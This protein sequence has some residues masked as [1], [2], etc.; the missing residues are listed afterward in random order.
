V[1]EERMLND[2][3]HKVVK[4]KRGD[5]AEQTNH[6][7]NLEDHEADRFHQDWGTANRDLKFLENVGRVQQSIGNGQHQQERLRGIGYEPR[8]E[9]RRQEP[10]AVGSRQGQAYRAE[11]PQ[12]TR[13]EQPQSRGSQKS[14]GPKDSRRQY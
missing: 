12:F 14:N 2:R 1:A 4:E 13:Q 6:Y 11:Q 5:Q 9:E 10:L 3:G 7:Y 8:R